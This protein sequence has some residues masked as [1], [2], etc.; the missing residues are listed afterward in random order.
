M[1]GNIDT[2]RI[3]DPIV[4][5][6]F[7]QKVLMHNLTLEGSKFI[8]LNKRPH[9]QHVASSLHCAPTL[10]C[11]ADEYVLRYRGSR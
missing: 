2:T 8:K 6:V 5:F 10:E 1:R 3:R 9:G 4:G 7:G 11:S